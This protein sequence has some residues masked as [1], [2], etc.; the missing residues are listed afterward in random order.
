[1]SEAHQFRVIF[2]GS[3]NVKKDPL[4]ALAG[5]LQFTNFQDEHNRRDKASFK[6]VQMHR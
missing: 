2:P 4:V 1:M 3:H 5:L 6:G